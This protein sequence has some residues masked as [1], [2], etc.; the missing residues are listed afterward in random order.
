MHENNVSFKY[1]LVYGRGEERDRTEE[2]K[3]KFLQKKENDI[4]V[5][6]FDSIKSAGRDFPNYMVLSPKGDDKFKV[7]E[8]PSDFDRHD[9]GFFSWV[10]A[11]NIIIEGK[12]LQQFT[13]FGYD[14]QSW[15]DGKAL[16]YNLKYTKDKW[17]PEKM[18][19]GVE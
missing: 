18:F 9:Q 14:M 11:E 7:K 1:L 6:T 16:S 5:C 19:S 2:R 4:R 8:L 13:D 15:L 10:T 3:A 17:C 12:C